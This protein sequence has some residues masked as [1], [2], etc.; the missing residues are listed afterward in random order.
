MLPGARLLA[1]NSPLNP[2]GTAF[3]ADALARISDLVLAENARRKPLGER[4]LYVMYDQVYW[5]LCFGGTTHVTPVGL[6]P[7][8][9]PYTVFV[10]GISKAFAATG[11]RV[12]WTMGP[13]DVITRMS[14]ILGHVGA[15][16]PRAE[17]AATVAL[18]QDPVAI[19]EFHHT[20]LSGVE[21]RLRVLHEGLQ[22]LKGDGLPVESIPPMGAIYLTA[23]LHPFGARTPDGHVLRTNDDIRRY[24]L[25]RAA[26][27]V[28]PFQAF[29]C[30]EEDGWFRLSVGA[31][32]VD[33]LKA[34]LPRVEAALRD[35]R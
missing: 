24:L 3:S 17:Q 35:L 11:L 15:W 12:G 28:V 31:V 34:A 29:G 22:R 9:A 32:S 16:A 20:F 8:I 14:S 4:P 13:L 2:T 27:A 26:F 7:E 33:E 23:R 21:A 5:T 25:E 6:R 18:L 10:D 1:L 19:G 30:T